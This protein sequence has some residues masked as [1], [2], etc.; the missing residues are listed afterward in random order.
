MVMVD[1]NDPSGKHLKD[2]YPG[3]LFT[4]FPEQLRAFIPGYLA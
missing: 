3:R 2:L 1:M 4:I